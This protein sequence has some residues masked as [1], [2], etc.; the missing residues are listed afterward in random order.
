MQQ[1]AKSIK[2]KQEQYQKRGFVEKG[3][4]EKLKDLSFEDKIEL[5]KSNIATERTIGARLLANNSNLNTI[6]YLTNALTTEKKLYTKIEICNS[7]VSFGIHAVNPLINLLGKIGNNQHS[8]ILKSQFKKKS[9]PLPRDIASRTII[10]IGEIALP[11]LTKTI[12]ENNI[13]NLTEAIDTIGYICFYKKHPEMYN[14]LERCFYKNSNNELIKWKIFR[15]M[16]AFHE[17]EIFLI[18]QKQQI[19]NPLIKSEIERS[20]SIINNRIHFK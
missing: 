1:F 3:K 9:Y 12:E 10:R 19:I 6:N 20:I 11:A 13:S 2:T 14:H 16:S 8:E 17:S 5:L 7:L 15:A 4:E 18:K